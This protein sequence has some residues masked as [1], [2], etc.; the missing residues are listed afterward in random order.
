MHTGTVITETQKLVERVMGEPKFF[1]VSGTWTIRVPAFS[2]RHAKEVARD[3]K[4][5]AEFVITEVY[6]SDPCDCRERACAE[7]SERREALRPDGMDLAKA[8]DGF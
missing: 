4:H 3:E 6:E 7:C 1:D 8:A 5:A 2:E